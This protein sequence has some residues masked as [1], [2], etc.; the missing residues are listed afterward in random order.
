MS[1]AFKIVDDNVSGGTPDT[2]TP[3]RL[4]RSHLLSVFLL[5]VRHSTLSWLRLMLVSGNSSFESLVMLPASKPGGVFLRSRFSKA[6]C[7]RNKLSVEVI[8][9]NMR[10]T[11]SPESIVDLKATAIILVI[12]D[13]RSSWSICLRSDLLISRF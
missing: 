13:A 2:L 11:W 12:A 7:S 10:L 6:R 5:I 1:L 9:C 3:F 8:F 4:M